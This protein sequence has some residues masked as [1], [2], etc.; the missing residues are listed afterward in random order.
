[1]WSIVLVVVLAAAA[2][3]F[4][5]TRGG[6]SVQPAYAL[7]FAAGQT[8]TYKATI[9]MNGKASFLGHTMPLDEQLTATMTWDVQSVDASGVATVDVAL[10]D[11][12]AT[13]NGQTLPTGDMPES[14][15]HSTMK[16]AQDGSVVSGS[17]FGAVASGGSPATSNVPGTDQLGPL[18]PGHDVHA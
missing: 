9:A 7:D 6:G 17:G 14:A 3:G 2:V 18:L 1:M 8:Y 12:Q 11:V 10:S 16:I 4:F 5:F 15:L 13:V